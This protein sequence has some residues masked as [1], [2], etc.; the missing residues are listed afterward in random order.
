MSFCV[1]DGRA[2][3]AFA[4]DTRLGIPPDDFVTIEPDIKGV[5]TVIEPITNLYRYHE[6]GSVE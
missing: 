1:M 5:W 2:E 6:S 3:I 4:D